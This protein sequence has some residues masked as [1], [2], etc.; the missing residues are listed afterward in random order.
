MSDAQFAIKMLKAFGLAAQAGMI[1]V[2]D[3][4]ED[5]FYLDGENTDMAGPFKNLDEVTA[6]IHHHSEDPDQTAFQA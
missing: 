6:Q 2:T 1:V 5:C 4:E 3:A